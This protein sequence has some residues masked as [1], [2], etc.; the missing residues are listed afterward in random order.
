MIDLAK[1]KD[2]GNRRQQSTEG[3]ETAQAILYLSLAPNAVLSK[4]K[5]DDKYEQRSF[6][7]RLQHYQTSIWNLSL[8]QKGNNMTYKKNNVNA[9]EHTKM[10]EVMSVVENQ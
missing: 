4:N 7:T 5:L 10:P 1:A 8:P 2:K 6:L 3:T 9:L